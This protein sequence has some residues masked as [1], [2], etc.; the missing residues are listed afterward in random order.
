MFYRRRTLFLLI[1]LME[2]YG[3]DHEFRFH[4]RDLILTAAQSARHAK[5]FYLVFFQGCVSTNHKKYFE[6]ADNNRHKSKTLSG[7]VKFRR[8]NL[9]N[10]TS[11]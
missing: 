2:S 10:E 8:L 6:P 3:W 5:G 11:G 4:Y 7:G 9:L 1:S